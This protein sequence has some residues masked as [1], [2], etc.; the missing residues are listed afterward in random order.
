MTHSNRPGEPLELFLIKR[1]RVQQSLA[2]AAIAAMILSSCGSPQIE[3]SSTF[4]GS[5]RV[6]NSNANEKIDAVFYENTEQCEADIKKQEAEYQK[7]LERQQQGEVNLIP[8]EPI[9]TVE[10][11]APQLLAAQQEHERTAPQYGS[12]ADCEEEGVQCEQVTS[13]SGTR[14]RP[15]YGGTYIYPYSY[16]RYTYVN[17]GGSRRRVYETRPVYSSATQGEVVTP[18]GRKVSKT[19]PGKVSVPRHTSVRAPQRPTGT[20]GRGTISGRS[21]KGFGSSYKGT[22][23]GGK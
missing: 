17:W 2:V 22:G 19:S 10:D 8:A 14:Y 12:K 18:Q 3:E 6:T 15:Y 7:Q 20:A 23:R 11:C 13:S 1:K 5:G 9:M 16:P 21:S 4:D